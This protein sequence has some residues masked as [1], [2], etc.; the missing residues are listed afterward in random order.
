MTEDATNLETQVPEQ[1]QPEPIGLG[2]SD[3]SPDSGDNHEQKQNSVQERINKITAEKYAAKR[4]AEELRKQLE[5]T[6]QNSTEVTQDV[7]TQSIIEE[8]KL[9]E[10]LYDE[11]AVRKYNADLIAYNRKVAQDAAKS[12]YQ[13]QLKEQEQAR[14]QAAQQDAVK[15]W[16]N[17]AQKSGVDLDKLGAAE[18]ALANAGINGELAGHLMA[19]PN[20]P[21]VA[22]HLAENPALMYEVLNMSPMAAAVKIET[23]IKAEAL[24]KTPRVS[25]APEPLPEINGGGMVEKDDFNRQFPDAEII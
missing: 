19:D 1:G 24:S 18:K 15:T 22:V 25:N 4:E 6:R 7:K 12:L 8:P 9:P 11:E 3:S 2:V 10:D 20:G 17:N 23:Q 5:A 16:A 14:A 13:D 21:A